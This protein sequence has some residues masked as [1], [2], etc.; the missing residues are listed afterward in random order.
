MRS[1]I[2]NSEK[3][4]QY[5]GINCCKITVGVKNQ[6]LQMITQCHI[7]YWKMLLYQQNFVNHRN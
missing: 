5:A 3:M 1:K 4:P 6:N 7:Q 2:N